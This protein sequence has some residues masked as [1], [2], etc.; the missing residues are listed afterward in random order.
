[1]IARTLLA[2]AALFLLVTPRPASA[3]S[4]P[5]M[6]QFE[7]F[8]QAARVAEVRVEETPG[9]HQAGMARLHVLRTLKGSPRA[10]LQGEETNTSCHVGYRTGRRAVVFLGPRGETIAYHEGRAGDP[11]ALALRAFAAAKDPDARVRALVDAIAGGPEAVKDEAAWYLANRPE[12]LA[13]ID[14]PARERLLAAAEPRDQPLLVVLA[15]LELDFPPPPPNHY[16]NDY[17]EL[18]A[19]LRPRD[20]LDDLGVEGLAEQVERG[21]EGYDPQRIRAMD[22]CERQTGRMLYPLLRYGHGL[23]G[24]FWAQLAAACR[25]GEPAKH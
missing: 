5:Y 1:M 8:E 13:R 10:T 17:A 22:R 16:R 20:E 19:L 11:Q 14:L 25:T 12:L 6:T 4:K 24:Q 15:R 21:R 9:R 2:A 23:P 3:C 7:L 18:A